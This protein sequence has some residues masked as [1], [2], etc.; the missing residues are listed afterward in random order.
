MP[1]T[2]RRTCIIIMYM[3]TM[4]TEANMSGSGD[5]GAI[6]TSYTKDDTMD[7]TM[8]DLESPTQEESM[9]IDLTEN[10]G[11]SSQAEGSRTSVHGSTPTRAKKRIPTASGLADSNANPARKSIRKL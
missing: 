2:T 4:R 11:L 3:P 10:T 8:S 7:L 5:N 1:L 9:I 6:D